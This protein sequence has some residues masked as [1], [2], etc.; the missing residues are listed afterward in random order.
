MIGP[1]ATDA[2]R[3]VPSAFHVPPRPF[4]TSVITS[5]LPPAASI[6]FS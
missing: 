4:A 1:Y 2:K 5:G 3:I 6:R